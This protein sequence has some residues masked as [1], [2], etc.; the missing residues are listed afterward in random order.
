M[1]HISVGRTEVLHVQVPNQTPWSSTQFEVM[2]CVLLSVGGV[3]GSYLTSHRPDSM[4]PS[5]V[6]VYVLCFS[7]QSGD[8]AQVTSQTPWSSALWGVG[9]PPEHLA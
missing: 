1:L 9:W 6:L 8:S 5:S 3:G 4:D 7:W 2:R